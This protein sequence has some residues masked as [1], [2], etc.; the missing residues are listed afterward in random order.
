MGS[1]EGVKAG[2]SLATY[3]GGFWNHLERLTVKA[4]HKLHVVTTDGRKWNK[5][6][7]WQAGERG[8]S[9]SHR[10]SVEPWTPDHHERLKQQT[11][12]KAHRRLCDALGAVKWNGE[13]PDLV[14]QV[15]ALVFKPCDEEL[16]VEAARPSAQP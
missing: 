15:H 14:A 11:R 6:T 2:D 9:W 8:D 1:L 4:V 16:R 7:G 13:S 12:D 5:R 3:G 10:A